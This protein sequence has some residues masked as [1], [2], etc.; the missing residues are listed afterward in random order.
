VQAALDYINN[1]WVVN[2]DP[3]YGDTQAMYCLLK[4]FESYGNPVGAPPAWFDDFTTLLFSWSPSGGWPGGSPVSRWSGP[5][6]S[7]CWALMVLEKVAP[8]PVCPDDIV[9]NNDMGECGAIVTFDVSAH[10]LATITQTSGL[11]SGSLFPIGITNQ[12][13]EIDLDDEITYCT[14]TVTVIDAEPP[15]P[16]LNP[17]PD[18]AVECE[19]TLVPPTATDNCGIIT[20]TTVDPLFYDVQGN[21]SVKWVYDDGN[22]NVI[23]QLQNVV[24]DDNTPPLP[25]IDPL[26]DVIG[27]CEATVGIPT[28]TDNCAGIVEATTSD[29]LVYTEQGTYV[30]NWTYDDGN[31][32]VV[33]QVQNVVVDDVTPPVITTVLQP[34]KLWPPNHKYTSFGLNDLVTGVTDNCSELNVS[35]VKIV[36]VTSDEPEDMYG[37]GDGKTFEDMIIADDCMSVQLRSEREGTGNGRV[38]TVYLELTDNIGNIVTS[39]CF[40]NVPHDMNSV[41]VDD[42]SVYEVLGDCMNK[43]GK[44]ANNQQEIQGYKLTNYPN[45]FSVSTTIEFT[46][47]VETPVMLK[48]YNLFGQEVVTLVNKKHIPGTYNV[49]F[50][51]AK[52]PAGQY[53]FRLNTS[54]FTITKK[55]IL[56]R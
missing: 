13:F 38:Y 14:F 54:E 51:A 4:G 53:L 50:D 35:D 31:G 41:A 42:G 8:P 48:V 55:M 6:I 44:I 29:P 26:P 30:V 34:I 5:I 45:P 15:V 10:Y 17:L 1:T 19:V 47:P 49:H 16:D 2:A 25:D 33:T 40:V 9:V 21:Y 24:V 12:E 39:V 43:S 23:V 32:N 11:P 7:T 27:E 28:A 20:G 22:G 37:N 46:V 3:G 36:K 56:N 18:V 52:L